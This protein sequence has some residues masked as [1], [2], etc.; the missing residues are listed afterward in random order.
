MNEVVPKTMSLLARKMKKWMIHMKNHPKSAKPQRAC[1]RTKKSET[2]RCID[3]RSREPQTLHPEVG[4]TPAK[5]PTPKPKSVTKKPTKKKP[6][7]P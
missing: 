7:R 4:R 2:W 3:R 6:P 1:S 5:P